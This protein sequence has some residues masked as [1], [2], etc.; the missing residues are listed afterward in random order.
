MAAFTFVDLPLSKMLYSRE[1]LFGFVLAAIGQMPGVFIGAFCAASLFALKWPRLPSVQ[2]MQSRPAASQW[3]L[4][5]VWLGL[6]AFALA[7]PALAIKVA[8]ECFDVPLYAMVASSVVAAPLFYCTAA[9]LNKHLESREKDA[10]LHAALTGFILFA[11]SMVVIQAVKIPWG[12]ARMRIL[13]EAGDMAFSQFSYWFLPQGKAA[14]DDYKSFPSGHAG[15]A[16]LVIWLTLLPTFLPRLN[17]K[18]AKIALNAAVWAWI[19]CVMLSRIIA[20]AH[21]ATDTIAGCGITLLCFCLSRIA[22]KR[23]LKA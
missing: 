11:V 4:T 22:A 1:N 16:A 21:F 10:F 14:S 19:L 6:G 8:D 3:L 23:I 9:Y 18:C 20:G 12:R 7:L 17:T 15:A 13:D 2:N 5:A